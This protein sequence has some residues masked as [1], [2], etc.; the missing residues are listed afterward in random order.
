MKS[1]FFLFGFILIVVGVTGCANAPWEKAQ[2]KNSI[3]QYE[4][5]IAQNPDNG[6]VA[7]AKVLLDSMSYFEAGS[8][9]SLESYEG[10]LAQF[11]EGNYEKDARDDIET[12]VYENAARERTIVIYKDYLSKY[13]MGAYIDYVK[14]DI[15]GLIFDEAL[16]SKN[17]EKLEAYMSQYPDG[18]FI[19][20]A[21]VALIELGVNPVAL[22]A[23][24]NLAE[25]ETTEVENSAA[26]KTVVVPSALDITPVDST[27]PKAVG[28]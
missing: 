24:K 10:Y 14:S 16:D 2:K 22:P 4:L 11:P 23:A 20:Q 25:E 8:I 12:L 6:K 5:F 28:Q 17:Q 19:G 1:T 26:V 3:K 21:A 7:E 15:E 9:G 18:D 13:P 27:V